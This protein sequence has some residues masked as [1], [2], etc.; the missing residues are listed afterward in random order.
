MCFLSFVHLFFDHPGCK[1]NEKPFH[2]KS[3]SQSRD[4][5]RKRFF[6]YLVFSFAQYFEAHTHTLKR[7]SRSVS[8]QIC[9]PFRMYTLQ[10]FKGA[11]LPSPFWCARWQQVSVAQQ[12]FTFPQPPHSSSYL[13]TFLSFTLPGRLQS[14]ESSQH[15]SSILLLSACIM[16]S[17]RFP[18]YNIV[19][20]LLLTTSD[21]V[22]DAPSDLWNLYKSSW[23]KVY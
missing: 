21:F 16:Y 10:W 1:C 9:F 13:W 8:I 15:K 7:A 3:Y 14:A 18:V 11:C 23:V 5:S 2:L 4:A 12:Y 19:S 20:I 17:F 6:F 22:S